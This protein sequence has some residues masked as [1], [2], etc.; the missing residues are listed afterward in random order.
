MLHEPGRESDSLMFAGTEKVA[1]YNDILLILHIV[2]D[3]H[4]YNL[5]FQ[6]EMHRC[7]AKF[8]DHTSGPAQTRNGERTGNEKTEVV[9]SI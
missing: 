9:G 4:V 3:G 1:V 5:K 2:L 7:K 8:Q 6:A